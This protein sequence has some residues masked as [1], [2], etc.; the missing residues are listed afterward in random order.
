MKKDQRTSPAE[1]NIV[2]GEPESYW[3]KILRHCVV[4][5]TIQRENRPP[6]ARI[7]WHDSHEAIK[8]D[9]YAILTSAVAHGFCQYRIS[10]T[11]CLDRVQGAFLSRVPDFAWNLVGSDHEKP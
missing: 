6:G 9:W 11:A 8:L 7:Q 10:F 4:S 2:F 3:K 1:E 5:S